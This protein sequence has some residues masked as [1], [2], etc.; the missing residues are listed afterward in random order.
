MT[1]QKIGGAIKGTPLLNWQ[2]LVQFPCKK[3]PYLVHLGN[4]IFLAKNASLI[5]LA[6]G[7][8]ELKIL[9]VVFILARFIL[10]YATT[11]TQKGAFF[12]LKVDLCLCAPC[13][14]GILTK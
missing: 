4:E 1:C 12:E 3:M 10:S 9:Q 2:K 14:V 7:G 5:P 13:T 11:E 6:D 8:F